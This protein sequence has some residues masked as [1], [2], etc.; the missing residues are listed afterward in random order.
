M[1]DLAIFKYQEKEVRVV[2]DDQG[3]PWFVAKDVCDVLS[4]IDTRTIIE[5]LDLDEWD[6]TTVIDAMGREQEGYIVSESGLYES[7]ARSNKPEAKVF[8]KWIRKEVVPS[9]RKHG[10]Y[11]TPETIEGILNDTETNI[12]LATNLKEERLKRLALEEENKALLP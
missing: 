12:K 9:I 7:I 10:A 1:N 2:K 6:K 4:I 8:Q 5:R 11:M 3:E